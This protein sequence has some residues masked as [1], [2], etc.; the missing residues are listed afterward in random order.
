LSEI[1]QAITI[2]LVLHGG[3]SSGDENLEKC[4]QGGI[5]KINIFTDFVTAAMTKIQEQQ[6]A[7]YFELKKAANQGM[8]D[9]LA[10]YYHVF[11]TKTC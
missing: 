7:D 1:H 11:H 5:R 10:H 8:A 2:P 4:A 9:T 3:S 6:P